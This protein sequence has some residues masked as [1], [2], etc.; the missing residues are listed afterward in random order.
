MELQKK[1]EELQKTFVYLS[2][3]NKETLSMKDETA[4]YQTS[5]SKVIVDTFKKRFSDTDSSDKDLFTK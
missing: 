4:K 5:G 1:N 2:E 3:Q